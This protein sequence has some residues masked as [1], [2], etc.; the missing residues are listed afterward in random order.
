MK[1]RKKPAKLFRRLRST[2][3]FSGLRFPR[4]SSAHG[5]KNNFAPI[6]EPSAGSSPRSRLP[7]LMPP[8][9]RRPFTHIGTNA[10]LLSEIRHQFD[11]QIAD[12]GFGAD[13]NLAGIESSRDSKFHPQ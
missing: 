1:S 7:G 3:C 9:T 8:V 4:S 12:T 6:W 11:S 13:K 2:G 5:T 10:V